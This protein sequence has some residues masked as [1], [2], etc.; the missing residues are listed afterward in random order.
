MSISI[1]RINWKERICEFE[2][3]ISLFLIGLPCMPKSLPSIRKVY[4]L[5][6][7]VLWVLHANL[8]SIGDIVTKAILL[9]DGKHGKLFSTLITIPYSL[10]SFLHILYNLLITK[11]SLPSSLPCIEY[12][13]SMFTFKINNCKNPL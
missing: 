2:M 6:Y 4:H 9:K 1:Y 12:N 11:K 8:Y 7:H 3:S 13:F 5:V 10:P